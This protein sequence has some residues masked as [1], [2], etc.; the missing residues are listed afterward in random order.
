MITPAVA[1]IIQ[2]D[3]R[4]TIKHNHVAPTTSLVEPDGPALTLEV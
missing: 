3:G 1:S 4:S 2:A